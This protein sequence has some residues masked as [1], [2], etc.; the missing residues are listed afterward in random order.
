MRDKKVQ[1]LTQAA[2]IAAIYVVL[3]VVFQPISY[4]EIQV[5]IAEALVVL[6]IF[7]P[8]AIPGIFVGCLLSNFIGGSIIIDV[9]CGSIASLI[10]AVGTYLLRNSKHAKVVALLPPIISNTIIVP[11]VLKIGYGVNLPIPFMMLTVGIGEVIAV[12][13]LGSVLIRALDKY[14]GKIFGVPAE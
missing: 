9:V 10:G 4:G 11:W 1:M 3:C 14:K 5:R 12:G 2:L 8:A 13:L 6:P 7:T